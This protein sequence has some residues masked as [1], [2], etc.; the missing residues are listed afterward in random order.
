MSSVREKPKRR[1]VT[2]ALVGLVI[3]CFASPV[4]IH[5]Q[6]A[7]GTFN[8]KCAVCHGKDGMGNTA[9]GKKVHVKSVAENI[10]HSEAD[11][12]KIVEDGKGDDMDGYKKDFSADQIKGLV[13]YY[14]GLAKK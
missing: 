1:S 8:K 10:S 5:A 7:E 4:A 9:K 13:D 2:I 6:D 11:Q 3:A 12:I 14:R